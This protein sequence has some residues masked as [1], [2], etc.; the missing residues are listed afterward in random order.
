MEILHRLDKFRAAFSSFETAIGRWLYMNINFVY[1]LSAQAKKEYRKLEQ[2]I[3]EELEEMMEDI[4]TVLN[5][6]SYQI[7]PTKFLN[8]LKTCRIQ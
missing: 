2:G 7:E 6:M 1:K 4:S 3:N 8:I 5:E